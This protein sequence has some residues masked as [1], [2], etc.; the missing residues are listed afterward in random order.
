M[1][2][3]KRSEAIICNPACLGQAIHTFAD[4]HVY[5]SMM[6]ERGQVVFL[7]NGIW[8][9]S[10]GD[11][12]ILVCFHRSIE[13]KILEIPG[14][15]AGA[16]CG[17]DAIEE[18]LDSWKVGCLGADVSGIVDAIPANSEAYTAWVGFFGTKSSHDSEVCGF[19]SF[20]DGRDWYKKHCFRARRH[21]GSMATTE[22]PEFVL[23]GVDP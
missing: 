10:D 8:D 2:C 3:E 6:H 1:R 23:A 22:T 5:V 11:P 14:H 21:F 4:F 13:I 12:Q 7:V 15:E 17:N 16:R 9:D 20:G 19:A 18:S